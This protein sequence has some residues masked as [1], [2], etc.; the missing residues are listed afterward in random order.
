[1]KNLFNSDNKINREDYLDN[2]NIISFFNTIKN[3][4][5]K[6]PLILPD[7]N[8][9]A[10][11]ILD[12]QN[13]FLN[14]NSHAFIPSSEK[15]I[16]KINNLINIFQKNNA[17]IIFTQHYNNNEH[18]QMKKW[19][20]NSINKDSND[21]LIHKSLNTDN[22]IILEKIYYDA[23]YKTELETILKMKHIENIFITGVMTHLCCESTARGAFL[24]NF[25]VYFFI[26]VTAT[27][28]KIFHLNT[29]I[30]LSHGFAN[31]L[32]YEEFINEYAK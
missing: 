23:F 28:N 14:K 10:L 18:I 7:I 15:I 17:S 30:N 12:M 32:L 27:Y 13:I 3:F 5:I 31:N 4:R 8:K 29:L 2:K 9:S 1:M 11:L 24:R 25:N 20:K 6:H 16:N 21:Y 19:W 22:S 26:D